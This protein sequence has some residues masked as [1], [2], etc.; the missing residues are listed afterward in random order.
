MGRRRRLQIKEDRVYMEWK[1]KIDLKN[2]AVFHEIESDRGI[3]IPNDLKRLISECNGATP[4]AYK[5]M[6]GTDEHV[7]GAILSFNKDEQDTDSVFTA[8][9]VIENRQ[10]MPFA[11][12]PFGNYFCVDLSDEEV[13]FWNHESGTIESSGRKLDDF[14]EEL[15]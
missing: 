10:M 5:C 13:V 14:L 9:K 11:I 12:D 2:T 4:S 6:F 7:I 3:I 1:Y 15:Y 8:L